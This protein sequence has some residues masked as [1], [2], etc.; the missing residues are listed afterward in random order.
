MANLLALGWPRSRDEHRGAVARDVLA[1]TRV[2]AL[3]VAVDKNA[4]GT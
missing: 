4:E 3:L 2:P 1:G